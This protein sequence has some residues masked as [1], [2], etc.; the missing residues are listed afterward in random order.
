MWQRSYSKVFKD[1]K[2]EAIWNLWTDIN[3]W[4]KWNPGVDY[5]K[6]DQPFAVGSTFTLKPTGGPVVKIDL[7]EVEAKRKFTDCTS[8]PGAKM[9]G[10]HEITKE[11]DGVRLTTTMTV[12]GPLGFLWRMIVANGIVAKTPKQA[13]QLV[14]LARKNN[15]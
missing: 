13:E 3:N 14:A 7:V 5:C 9:Y 10:M 1:V 12:T 2:P 4:H 15:A 6:L 11:K 8:F